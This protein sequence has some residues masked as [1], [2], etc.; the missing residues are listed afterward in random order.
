MT[1]RYFLDK[2]SK[3]PDLVILPLE[4]NVLRKDANYLEKLLFYRE[5]ARQ[6]SKLFAVSKRLLK[7]IGGLNSELGFGEDRE[8]QQRIFS[9]VRVDDKT[10]KLFDI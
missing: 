3:Y 10:R 2:K 1:Y 8:L 4:L 9:A 7:K 5:R 6:R